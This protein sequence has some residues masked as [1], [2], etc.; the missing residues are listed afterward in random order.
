MVEKETIVKEKI[1]YGGLGDIK[2]AYKFARDWFW[3]EEFSL[4]EDVYTEKVSGNKRDIYFEWKATREVS[5]YFNFENSIKSGSK[6]GETLYK[7]HPTG[8][9]SL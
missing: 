8:I 2:E 5:D 6:V 4:V 9:H 7:D 3:K 1:K